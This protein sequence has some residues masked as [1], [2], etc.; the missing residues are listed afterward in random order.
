M[1]SRLTGAAAL[2][3]ALVGAAFGV[4][5]AAQGETVTFSFTGAGQT[6]TVPAGVTSL[7]IVAIG[8]P[9]GAG[10]FGGGAG[11]RG[12]AVGADVA[13]TPGETL[14]VLVGG[15]GAIGTGGFNGGGTGGSYS[16][17]SGGGGG[18]A[19]D[20][21][22]M[23]PIDP[24]SIATRL[25]VAAGGGGGTD[26]TGVK[27]AGGDG[28]ADGGAFYSEYAGKAATATAGGAGGDNGGQPGV[29]ARGGAGGGGFCTVGTP[30]LGGGGGG[31]I[32][33]GGGGG[34]SSSGGGGGGG[35]SGALSPRVTNVATAPD[36]GGVA[37]VLI[38]PGPAAVPAPA[39]P[40]P[41]APGAST[42]PPANA[43]RITRAIA[44]RDG[45]I[46]VTLD[47]PGAGTIAARATF[48]RSVRRPGRP[49]RTATA[50]Y[51]TARATVPGRRLV[52]L[53]LRPSVTAAATVRRLRRLAVSVGVTFTP[54]GGTPASQSARVAVRRR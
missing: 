27:A 28:D 11:G 20:V 23:M 2:T 35:S 43:F 32:Y 21:R 8:A 49:P 19:S 10:S 17:S 44:G 26:A 41:A 36:T 37:R 42:P 25:L 51:G 15:A 30:S 46:R 13:V 12:A 4:P 34:C 5:A 29:L 24:G 54:S 52:T 39:P 6:Y 14:H 50:T 33:G 45:A 47:L 31:G 18:G 22:T 40:P 9:G 16:T 1:I 53:R 7:R 48:R 3:V 38:T